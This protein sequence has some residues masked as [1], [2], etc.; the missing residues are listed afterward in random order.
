MHV[1]TCVR[2]CGYTCDMLCQ[3]TTSYYI[4]DTCGMHRLSNKLTRCYVYSWAGGGGGVTV[5][6]TA[7]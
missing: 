4:I 3:V 5:A 7:S 1:H 2:V 6:T